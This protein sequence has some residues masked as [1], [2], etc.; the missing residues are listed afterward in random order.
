M[1][2]EAAREILIYLLGMAAKK[3]GEYGFDNEAPS[4]QD[5][6][7]E[8][9]NLLTLCTQLFFYCSADTRTE[10]FSTFLSNVGGVFLNQFALTEAV[11][12]QGGFF[13]ILFSLNM[14]TITRLSQIRIF[15]TSHLFTLYCSQNRS[16]PFAKSKVL[17][18][19]LFLYCS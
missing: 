8:Q 2:E 5:L 19:S 16:I 7:N 9:K 18:M 11:F 3:D 17:E 4:L 10:L 6:S 13:F 12:R 15:V 14:P 1:S